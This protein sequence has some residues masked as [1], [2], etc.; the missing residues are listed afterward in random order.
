M[1]QI[2]SISYRKIHIKKLD[3]NECITLIERLIGQLKYAKPLG[4]HTSKNTYKKISTKKVK[5]RSD[6]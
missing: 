3:Q 5:I 6:G 1:D 2:G 4:L